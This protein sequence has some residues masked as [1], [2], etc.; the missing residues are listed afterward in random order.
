MSLV[1]TLWTINN[2]M[3][4]ACTYYVTPVV[5]SLVNNYGYAVGLT[6]Y[7]V[8]KADAMLPINIYRLFY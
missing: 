2:T 5:M 4:A 6:I 8:V 7:N 3:F 1:Y